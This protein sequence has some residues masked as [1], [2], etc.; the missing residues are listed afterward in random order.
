MTV[1]V[2][3]RVHI[4]GTL[5]ETE[6]DAEIERLK[7]VQRQDMDTMLESHAQEV[8]ELHDQLEHASDNDSLVCGSAPQS[9]IV[10]TSCWPHPGR[11]WI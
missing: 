8:S 4:I 11:F 3:V 2:V 10:L 1:Y 5:Q 9:R 7:R 6:Y